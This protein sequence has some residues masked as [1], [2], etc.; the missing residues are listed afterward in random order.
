MIRVSKIYKNRFQEIDI[1]FKYEMWKILCTD[2]FQ[3]YIDK[4][5]SV[6]D[7]ACG[8]CEFINNIKA[9]TK[10][11]VDINPDSSKYADKDISFIE[12]HSDSIPLR[13]MSVDTIF[14]SNFFEHITREQITNT[15]V[16]LRRLLKKDGRI[17]VLQPNIRF[18]QKDYW[19]FFDHITPIDDRALDEVFEISGFKCVKKIERF[20]PYTTK[21]ILLK[22]SILV[23]LYLTIPI[24][25]RIFGKQSFMV[26]EKYK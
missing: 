24:I 23:R 4:D 20:L 18:L 8:Y 14:I 1:H 2:F 5:D 21:G 17:I 10:Y 16:E 26:Y 19:M 9:K 22:S 12:A 3:Q 15:I 7:L 25:W 11:A 13:T 6:L